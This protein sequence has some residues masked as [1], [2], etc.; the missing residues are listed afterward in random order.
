M[1]PIDFLRTSRSRHL[2]VTIH[3]VSKYMQ[4]VGCEAENPKNRDYKESRLNIQFKPV[5]A[6][7]EQHTNTTTLSG[8]GKH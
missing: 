7:V 4:V 8:K 1:I 5:V 6:S 3:N 2:V